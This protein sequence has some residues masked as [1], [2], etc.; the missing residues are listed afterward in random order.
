MLSMNSDHIATDG[1]STVLLPCPV[2]CL[3]LSWKLG[4]GTGTPHL[5]SRVMQRGRSPS[6]IHAPVV[7]T[8]LLLHPPTTDVSATY[9]S[10]LSLSAGRSKKRCSVD[11]ISGG[12]PHIWGTGTGKQGKRHMERV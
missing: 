11:R 6:L 1:D 5:R 3:T 8:E 12:L 10:S 7:C 2:L 4:R 9:V